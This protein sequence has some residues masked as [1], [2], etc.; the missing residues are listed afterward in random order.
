MV[1]IPR[2]LIFLALVGVVNT[3]LFRKFVV[4]MENLLE[5]NRQISET[6]KALLETIETLTSTLATLNGK[7][8]SHNEVLATYMYICQIFDANSTPPGP[9]K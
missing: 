9:Q 7:I 1:T 3:E 2:V 4:R 5:T 8:F 6:N